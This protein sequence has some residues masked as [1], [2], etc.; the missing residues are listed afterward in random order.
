MDLGTEIA[1]Y[2]IIS[3]TSSHVSIKRYQEYRYDITLKL[4]NLGSGNYE[5]LYNKLIEQISQ[6]P[7]IYGVKNP[8]KCVIDHPSNNSITQDY[9]GNIT[10]NLTG[11]S[12]RT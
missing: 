6:T 8:Y 12:Y 1:G 4:Q 9:N 7:I 10:V 11:H 2:K 3:A 5:T